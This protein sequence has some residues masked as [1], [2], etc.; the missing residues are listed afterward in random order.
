MLFNI[1]DLVFIFGKNGYIIIYVLGRLWRLNKRK[2]LSKSVWSM[3][4]KKML[5]YFFYFWVYILYFGFLFFYVS[6]F[7]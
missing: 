4:F 5:F 7:N 2:D 6:L 3:D 1:W